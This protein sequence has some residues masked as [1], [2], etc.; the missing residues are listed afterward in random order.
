MR[1]AALTLA[2]PLALP[3]C[4]SDAAF[5]PE[6]TLETPG[7]FVAVDDVD[8]VEGEGPLTLFRTLDTVTLPSDTVV[9]VTIYNVNPRT[10]EEAR[11]MSKS[12]E[13]PIRLEIQLVSSTPLVARPYRVVWW[14]SLTAEEQERIP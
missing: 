4:S 9:F 8:D 7:A 2:I 11:E 3:A 13:I 6:P 10:W 1:C 14:R 5:E 12:H